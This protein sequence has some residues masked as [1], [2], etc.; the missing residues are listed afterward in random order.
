MNKSDKF[1]MSQSADLTFIELAELGHSIREL[2]IGAGGL[3]LPDYIQAAKDLDVKSLGYRR[4]KALQNEKRLAVYFPDEVFNILKEKGK[5]VY[6]L[7]FNNYDDN[8]IRSHAINGSPWL[9]KIFYTNKNIMW[10]RANKIGV[11][12]IDS[13]RYNKSV[14][15]FI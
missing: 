12:I 10:N 4:T 13:R 3:S 9:A 15:D 6:R 1:L 7:T 5:D 8:F 11:K 2:L 14:I